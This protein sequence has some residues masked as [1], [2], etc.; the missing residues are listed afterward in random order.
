MKF[1]PDYV[2]EHIFDLNLYRFQRNI[3]L[4]RMSIGNFGVTIYHCREK[5]LI[6]WNK[7]F[8]V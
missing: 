5:H 4:K 7:L 3:F 6:Y 8:I 2:V 1:S